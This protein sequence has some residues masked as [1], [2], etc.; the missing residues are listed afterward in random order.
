MLETYAR[1]PICENKLNKKWLDRHLIDDLD[2]YSFMYHFCKHGINHFYS[3][4]SKDSQIQNMVVT[5][6]HN[7][8][9]RINYQKETS[10]IF[11]QD[12]F[13]NVGTLE[14]PKLLP[15]DF[16]KLDKL[17]EIIHLYMTFL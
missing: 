13:A 3:S 11:I 10:T 8:T 17:K 16:P 2:G 5:L 14:I 15:T 4:L 12:G 1:C 7:I 9:V 6:N